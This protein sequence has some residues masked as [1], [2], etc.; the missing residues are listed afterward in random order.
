MV[1][2]LAFVAIFT[3]LAICLTYI[4][5]RKNP[6]PKSYIVVV[7]VVEGLALVGVIVA[8]IFYLKGA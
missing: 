4:E 2:A 1:P 7:T 6:K 5:H 3:V 8:L